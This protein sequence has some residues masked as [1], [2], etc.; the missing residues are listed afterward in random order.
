MPDQERTVIELQITLKGVVSDLRDM[1]IPTLRA[2]VLDNDRTCRELREQVQ[3]LHDALFVSHGA[4]GPIVQ[5][6]A[7]L[8][9]NGEHMAKSIR[10]VK[11]AKGLG[12]KERLAIYAA[13]A[14]A[15]GSIVKH[16]LDSH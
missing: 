1:N 5:Q 4:D 11:D 9:K 3:G 16:Y 10:E 14:G 12:M 13:L 6:V 7:F 8:R 2:T 15:I